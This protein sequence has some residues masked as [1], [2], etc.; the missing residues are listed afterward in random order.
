LVDEKLLDFAGALAV[1]LTGAPDSYPDFSYA[2]YEGNVAELR[3]SWAIAR[4]NIKSDIDKASFIDTTL[5][6]AIAA[7]DAGDKARG[8]NC[9]LAIYNLG[10]KDLR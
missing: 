4:L 5:E 6:Q 8:R 3:E 7:F 9:I 2:T 10:V 1:A